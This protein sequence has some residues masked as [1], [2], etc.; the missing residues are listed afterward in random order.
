MAPRPVE[1][2]EPRSGQGG[3]SGQ[4]P[5]RLV[6]VVVVWAPPAR[7]CSTLS[8]A[9]QASGGVLDARRSSAAASACPEPAGGR[10]PR[11]EVRCQGRRALAPCPLARIWVKSAAREKIDIPELT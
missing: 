2:A 4:G 9:A 3:K 1:P 10:D 5:A 7:T 11:L 6:V 8:Q